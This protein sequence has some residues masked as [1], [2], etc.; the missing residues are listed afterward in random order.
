MQLKK[1]LALALGLWLW[2]AR[3][4]GRPGDS[5]QS[6]RLVDPQSATV[7]DDQVILIRDNKD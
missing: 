1:A 7:L 3:R 5:N 6:G 2:C 4:C